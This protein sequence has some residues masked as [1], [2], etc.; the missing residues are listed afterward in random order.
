MDRKS[1]SNLRKWLDKEQYMHC[2][3]YS[4][5]AIYT[6]DQES[7]ESF[8]KHLNGTHPTSAS[9]PINAEWQGVDAVSYPDKT[10]I[11]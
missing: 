7:K 6:P 2:V 1:I 9:K 4:Q 8:W 10:I 11:F 3:V 5:V